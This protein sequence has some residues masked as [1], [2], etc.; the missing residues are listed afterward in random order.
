MVRKFRVPDTRAFSLGGTVRLATAAP[1][2]VLDA[3]LGV[4]AAEDGGITVRA[5]EHLPGDVR[6]AAHRRSTATSTTAWSTAFGDPV[7]QWVRGADAVTGDVRPSRPALVADGRHSVPTQLRIDAGGESRTVDVGPV[8]DRADLN[9]TASV[10]VS[11]P[12][13]HRRRRASHRHRHPPGDDDRVPRE[14]TDRDARRHRGGRHTGRHAP[15]DAGTAA[16]RVPHRP[17]LGRWR[18]G[19]SSIERGN[20]G[21]AAWRSGRLRALRGSALARRGRPPRAVDTGYVDRHRRRRRGVGLRRHRCAR[22]VGAGGSLA[23]FTQSVESAP[24]GKPDVRVVDDGRTK[25][26]LRISGAEPG[27]PFWL[28]LGESNSKGW[29]A[30]VANDDAS[31]LSGPGAGRST[32]VD[33][34]ANGWLVVPDSPSF[35]VALEWTPQRSVWV[36]LAISGAALLGCVAL[37]LWPRR[38]VHDRDDDKWAALDGQPD[39]ANP[40]VAD[41]DTPRG[42]G[43]LVATLVAGLTAAFL[44]RWWIGLVVA[45]CLL[46]HVGTPAFATAP[47][48]WCARVPRGHRAVR[49]RPAVPL[50]VP[51]RFLLGRAFQR[52]AES[53]VARG[54]PARSRRVRGLHCASGA[55]RSENRRVRPLNLQVRRDLDVEVA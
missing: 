47:D 9:A 6:R 3:V 19:R 11:V 2:D 48:S 41:G 23:N 40:F 18:A 8:T 44:A 45:A 16:I 32:L 26:E 35:D 24:A 43:L 29:K 4:R 39:L 1:D 15:A 53:R 14:P 5:S 42:P 12:A 51:V 22:F 28:V 7:G 50:S 36:A 17:A 27:V 25:K 10:P 31:V 20:R 38:R 54:A 52:G 49:H 37:A 33:G 13:A 30:T 55:E 46:A 21:G 34:Y